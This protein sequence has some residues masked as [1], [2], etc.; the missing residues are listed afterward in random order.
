MVQPDVIL[1]L[2]V[3][4]KSKRRKFN[5]PSHCYPNRSDCPLCGETL[6]PLTKMCESC[7]RA[8]FP[9]D[10]PYYRPHPHLGTDAGKKQAAEVAI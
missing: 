7:W 6:T 9:I 3:A 10:S 8:D 2:A 4:V 1:H 5:F